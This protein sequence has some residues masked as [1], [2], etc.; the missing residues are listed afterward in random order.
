M[1]TLT[2]RSTDRLQLFT[3]LN[4]S[5]VAER[6]RFG[7]FHPFFTN[8]F[9]YLLGYLIFVDFLKD[10]WCLVPFQTSY[11]ALWHLPHLSAQR[12]PVEHAQ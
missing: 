11:D 6:A 4:N 7:L 3:F 12:M 8:R 9:N 1:A 2:G 5:I 10:E